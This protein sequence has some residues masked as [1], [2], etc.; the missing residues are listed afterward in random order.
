MTILV[1]NSGL[2]SIRAIVF[3]SKGK[4]FATHHIPIT[5]K[6]RHKIVEQDP[7]EWW[8]KARQAVSE[9]LKD[10]K[11]AESVEYLTITCSSSCLVCVDKD[12][13]S[14]MNSIMV[15]EKGLLNKLYT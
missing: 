6:L 13:N 15:S 12:S 8:I 4:K 2:K 3:N 10:K 1:I 11:I 5:I 9:V 14:L 7:E